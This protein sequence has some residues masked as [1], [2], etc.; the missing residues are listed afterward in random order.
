MKL[1]RTPAQRTGYNLKLTK[2]ELLSIYRVVV[3][4]ESGFDYEKWVAMLDLIEKEGHRL[5]NASRE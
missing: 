3:G 1:T 4:S 2:D 5:G